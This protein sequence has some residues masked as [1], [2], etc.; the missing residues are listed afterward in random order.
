MD[1]TTAAALMTRAVGSW[2]GRT[3]PG[4]HTIKLTVPKKKLER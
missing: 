1:N 2:N 4:A 3:A